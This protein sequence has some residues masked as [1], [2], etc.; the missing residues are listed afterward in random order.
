MLIKLGTIAINTFL[1]MRNK[2]VY[3]SGIKTH[4]WGFRE[5]LE[6]VFHLLLVVE[7]VFLKKVVKTLEEVVVGW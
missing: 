3:S 5:L 1:P 4:A 6:G 2:F 7:A